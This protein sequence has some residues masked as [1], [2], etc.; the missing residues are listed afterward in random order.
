MPYEIRKK[1][2]DGSWYKP[3]I[4]DI[5]IN[6]PEMHNKFV[7]ETL[8]YYA[9]AFGLV[10]IGGKDE[11]RYADNGTL[12]NGETGHWE[13]LVAKR[14]KF[15]NCPVIF[16]LGTNNGFSF[17]LT[18]IKK[19]N[20]VYKESSTIISFSQGGY[21]SYNFTDYDDYSNWINYHRAGVFEKITD[22]GNGIHIQYI[23]KKYNNDKTYANDGARQF[24]LS[25]IPVYNF[26]TNEFYD[27]AVKTYSTGT[28]S[29]FAYENWNDIRTIRTAGQPR[30]AQTGGIS[31][32]Y[33]TLTADQTIYSTI[34]TQDKYY[35]V[36]SCIAS[37]TFA[38]GTSNPSA[39]ANFKSKYI[40]HDLKNER[41]LNYINLATIGYVVYEN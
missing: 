37:L 19:N 35:T 11:W 31:S 1:Y 27:W 28:T 17:N 22:I 23:T 6:T 41:E 14:V 3:Y 10:G 20:N 39:S 21:N 12:P 30:L 13:Q 9:D 4:D 2:Y 25:V 7:M 24:V 16:D 26:E 38:S 32:V 34:A 15:E 5:R 29:L 33:P 36:G 40:L 18:C 8:N